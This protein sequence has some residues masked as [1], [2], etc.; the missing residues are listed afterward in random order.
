MVDTL[1]DA[2][3][4]SVGSQTVEIA[5]EAII[6]T[7]PRLRRWIDETRDDLR[8]RQRIDRAAAEWDGQERNPALLYRGTPL[9]A[10]LEWAG[11]HPDELSGLERDFL[12][13]SDAARRAEREEAEAVAR[14]RQR[15]R[16]AA[17]GALSVL[18]TAAVIASVV[19]L[20]ALQRSRADA[21]DARDASTLANERFARALATQSMSASP[22]IRC[23]ESRSRPRASPAARRRSP[24]RAARSSRRGS[25]APR[26]RD[27]FR[28]AHRSRWATRSRSR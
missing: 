7:W 23:S 24:R 10:A 19:A 8:T 2:R 22:T 26:R 6:Q 13:S 4:L 15:V 17:I 9:D 28:S 25:P 18:A 3:L 14:R 5:H 27:R 21:R 20:V 16:W 11:G 1:A 12:D